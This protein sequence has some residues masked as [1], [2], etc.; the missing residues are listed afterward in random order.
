MFYCSQRAQQSG[1][2]R[3]A[4]AQA[5]G[6]VL[7]SSET[8]GFANQ[9]DVSD[10]FDVT[11]NVVVTDQL[12]G[13]DQ[14]YVIDR[15][16]IAPSRQED[17]T[18]PQSWNRAEISRLFLQIVGEHSVIWDPANTKHSKKT[19]LDDAWKQV[20]VKFESQVPVQVNCMKRV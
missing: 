1:T 5:L 14:I 15:I 20:K 10:Q 17:E 18:L 11:D 9:I 7:V 8:D 19:A 13:T 4:T 12:D 6:P 16:D 2:N 3:Q